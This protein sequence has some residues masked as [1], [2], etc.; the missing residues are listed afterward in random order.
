[1][2]PELRALTPDEVA[3][4]FRRTLKLSEDRERELV[5]HALTRLEDCRREMLIDVSGELAAEGWMW[6]RVV[7]QN[8]YD[9]LRDW[10]T[11]WYRAGGI[12]TDS[13]LTYGDA[14]RFCRQLAAKVN[15]DIVN[16]TPFFTSMRVDDQDPNAKAIARGVE[17]LIQTHVD[18]SNVQDELRLAV[19][20]ALIRNEAVVKINYDHRES[21]FWGEATVL[22]GLDGEAIHTSGGELIYQGDDFIAAPAADAN[23]QPIIGADGQPVQV[24]QLRKDPTFRMLPN[25]YSFRFFSN[26]RQTAKV[27]RTVKLSVVDHRS[28][29]C[30]LQSEDIHT[31]DFC[32]D[33]AD[34]DIQ[35]L[36]EQFGGFD[37]FDRYKG[38]NGT[39]DVAG[40]MKPR[41]A[42]G[43]Q[44]Q[45][46]RSDALPRRTIA[47]CY[48][49]WDADEDGQAEE[50]MII[51]DTVSREALFYDYM[52]NHLKKRPYEVIVGLERVPSRWY[53]IGVMGRQRDSSL[54]ADAQLNRINARD[55]RDSTIDFAHANAVKEWKAGQT[56]QLGTKTV[57]M[58]EA[59]YNPVQNPPIWRQNLRCD[60]SECG[61][62]ATEDVRQSAALEFGVL[63]NQEISAQGLNASRTAT[64]VL[65]TERSGNTLLRATENDQVKGIKAV[66]E[67]VIDVILENLKPQE[68]FF[69]P[70]AQILQ[71]LSIEEI[72]ELPRT[73]KLLLTR[74]RST[75][76]LA[77]NQQASQIVLTWFQ[78]R[79]TDP[80][81]A[82]HC[83]P[84]FLNQ[85]KGLEIADADE[86]IPEITD[87]ELKQMQAS[88]ANA[89]GAQHEREMLNLNYKDAPPEIQAQIEARLG[90]KP[91]S[92]A[93]RAKKA[94]IEN[95]PKDEPG[96]KK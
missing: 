33:L 21:V 88:Q 58:V 7:N 92:D 84:L 13:N 12:F 85:L 18:T 82:K 67:Q 31:A 44:Y 39:T 48:L 95:P 89:A 43:E 14:E 53:G 63:S 4:P 51:I 29:Y 66:L 56:I 37:I 81:A 96:P 2:K 57:Y 28:F 62:R 77:T 6:H 94:A 5:D 41:I 47:E 61:I 38:A 49:R 40:E 52:F 17:E 10:R 60:L 26:I 35:S 68:L 76:M 79:N 11:T 90:F 3:T 83:R 19:R 93:E 34:R 80:Y 69:S 23:G 50:I 42:Q 45:L 65:N 71:S 64:G 30:P 74:S 36:R 78:L 70:S 9:Q 54:Y 25:Q 32:C 20:C 22:V 59:G 55:S 16:T 91:V 87:E 15:D 75:E 72:R 86:I 24:F 46:G 73:V 27:S 1:M 8:T